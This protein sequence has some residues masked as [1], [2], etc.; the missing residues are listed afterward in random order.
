MGGAKAV[1]ARMRP[2]LAPDAAGRWLKDALNADR[3]EQLHPSQVIWLLKAAR[4]AGIHDAMRWMAGE[5]GYT[6]PDPTSPPDE[7]AELQRQFIAAS[8]QMQ[9]MTARMES[10]AGSVQWAA[11]GSEKRRA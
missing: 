11:F 6:T 4:E 9:N 3:R 5:C 1:G 10:I 8:K 2:D 7:M